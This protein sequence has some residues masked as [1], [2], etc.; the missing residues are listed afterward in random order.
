MTRAA[1]Y[2]P[3]FRIGDPLPPLYSVKLELK[4]LEHLTLVWQWEPMSLGYETFDEHGLLL[5]LVQL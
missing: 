2:M 3:K 1:D 4:T 5:C